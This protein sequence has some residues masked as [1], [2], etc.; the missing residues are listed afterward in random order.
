MARLR[1]Q[2]E[3]GQ[4]PTL[5]V[6]S[7]AIS[8]SACSQPAALHPASPH[9]EH[10]AGSPSAELPPA[11]QSVVRLPRES[12]VGDGL[13]AAGCSACAP[14]IADQS[15]D[16]EEGWRAAN[17]AE[18]SGS[19]GLA[20]PAAAALPA[21]G[22]PKQ[23]LLQPAPRSPAPPAKRQALQAPSPVSSSPASAQRRPLWHALTGRL[24]SPGKLTHNTQ[25]D[26]ARDRMQAAAAVA[27]T[28]TSPL[29]EQ[30]AT[31]PGCSSGR[32]P[33]PIRRPAVQPPAGAAATAPRRGSTGQ[34]ETSP[35][36]SPRVPQS[37]FSPGQARAVGPSSAVPQSKFSPLRVG[38]GSSPGT[39]LYPL[40]AARAAAAASSRGREGIMQ[41]PPPPSSRRTASD[42]LVD[43]AA[44]RSF[45]VRRW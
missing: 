31:S 6:Q 45:L 25:M 23:E 44:V 38:R 21:A 29:A 18:A 19:S 33:S 30:P 40:R 20:S 43:Q 35:V 13:Q 32:N 37:K 7:G 27:T 14:A 11:S 4:G 1:L 22:T 39:K 24:F 28:A 42:L 17:H 2:D 15:R 26:A 16:P 36:I 12:C 41:G 5:S 8:S 9:Q 34:R 10:F 3:H